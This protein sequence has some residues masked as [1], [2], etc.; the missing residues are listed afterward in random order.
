MEAARDQVSAALAAA[1][2][3]D[4]VP[5]RV[6][7]AKASGMVLQSLLAVGEYAADCEAA[8]GIVSALVAD[9]ASEVRLRA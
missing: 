2:K 9:D 6:A 1:A 5:I 4:K 3:D 7:A 8:A